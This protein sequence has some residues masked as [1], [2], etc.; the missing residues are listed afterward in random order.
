M[1]TRKNRPWVWTKSGR[2]AIPV[3]EVI[4]LWVIQENPNKWTLFTR[5]RHQSDPITIGYWG[6]EAEAI[7]FMRSITKLTEE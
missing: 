4:K 3:D 2:G 1:E 5:V 7:E 6:T